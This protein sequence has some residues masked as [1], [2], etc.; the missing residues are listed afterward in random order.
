MTSSL[1]RVEP[2]SSDANN[3]DVFMWAVHLLGGASKLVDVEDIYF[4][5]FELAP[6]RL[7]W[8]T[9]PEVPNFKKTAKALQEIEAKS[10]VGLLQKM[11]P[12]FRR[13]T[14]AGVAWVEKYEH[15]L[16]QVYGNA[17]FVTAPKTS[18]YSRRLRAIK[19]N[20]VWALWTAGKTLN[21][22]YLGHILDCSKASPKEIWADRIADLEQVARVTNDAEFRKFLV[23]AKTTLDRGI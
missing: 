19:S 11:G 3:T 9:R 17:L 18:D 13:L 21:M 8:R 23:D 16:G 10:H 6:N 1:T 15:I 14:P 2:P 20:D 7:G 5:A 22:N 4:K 12:N